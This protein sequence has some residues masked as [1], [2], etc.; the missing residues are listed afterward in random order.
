MAEPVPFTPQTSK[1]TKRAHTEVE[2]SPLGLVESASKRISPEMLE[3]EAAL[4]RAL[5]VALQCQEVKDSLADTILPQVVKIVDNEIRSN[6]YIKEQ[7]HEIRVERDDDQ[8]HSRM[9]SIRI[10]NAPPSKKP[11]DRYE[12]TNHTCLNIFR[13]RLSCNLNHRDLVI[14]HRLPQRGKQNE[15]YDPIICHFVSNIA[16]QEVMSKQ[17]LLRDQKDTDGNLMPR[18]EMYDDLTPMKSKAAYEARQL[19]KN[20]VIADTWVFR[21]KIWVTPHTGDSFRIRHEV[22]LKSVAGTMPQDADPSR[23]HKNVR[24]NQNVQSPKSASSG[25]QVYHRYYEMSSKVA[26]KKGKQA[27]LGTVSD[28]D[29]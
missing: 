1:P 22:D 29:G 16:K 26:Q 17:F 23:L 10:L 3:D 7:F 13:N 18:I 28:T 5:K 19:K 15:G 27:A 2:T 6:P 11:G 12:N 25:P 8:Q 24:R 9:N 20:K 14:S 4:V 21:G